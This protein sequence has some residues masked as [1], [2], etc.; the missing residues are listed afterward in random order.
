M[1]FSTIVSAAVAA[2]PIVASAAGTMGFALG[3]KKSDGTCKEA[4]D[5]EADFAAIGKETSAKVVRIY[6][7]SDCDV[8]SL[9]LPAAKSAGFKVVLGI[10]PDTDES[11]QADKKAVVD[12]APQYKDQ[13]Y[14]ITVGS[15]SLYRGNFTGEELATKIQD[16]RSAVGKGFK[17]GTADSWN[18]YADGTA[19]AVITSGAADI[20]LCNAFSYWQGQVLSNATGSFY[21]DIYQAFGHI[22]EK[23]GSTDKIELWVGE[24]GWPTDGDMYQHAQPGLEE[25]STFYSQAVCGMVDWGFNVFFFEAFDEEWKPHAVGEDGSVADETSWGAMKADRTA[26]YNLKC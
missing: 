19:D 24:T 18:K 6:A 16:V 20:L 5:Y 14:A 25:A 8:A 21:D 1:R 9:I 7:A 26:K 2:G 13:V 15:E 11:F 17:V 12:Y 23:A 3:N 22:Q 10:W 4:D